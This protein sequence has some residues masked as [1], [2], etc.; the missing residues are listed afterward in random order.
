MCVCVCVR[1]R[2]WTQCR[3]EKLCGTW[4]CKILFLFVTRRWPFLVFY[5]NDPTEIG[6]PSQKPFSVNVINAKSSRS[7]KFYRTMGHAISL[8]YS[9]IIFWWINVEFNS[10]ISRPLW[11]DVHCY[12]CISYPLFCVIPYFV[13][14]DSRGKYSRQHGWHLFVKRK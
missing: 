14:F 13:C 1:E 2:K 5:T 6:V 9:E 12:R 11:S 4:L 3:I 10:N 7:P 8:T